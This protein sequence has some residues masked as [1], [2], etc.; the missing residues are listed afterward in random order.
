MDRISRKFAGSIPDG[1]S[2]IFHLHNPSCRPIAVGSTQPLTEMSTR[3]IVWRREGKVGRCLGLTTLPPSCADGLKSGS[4]NLLEP[5]GP[6]QACNG[7][8]LPLYGQNNIIS[9]AKIWTLLQVS[10]AYRHP[11]G[12][13]VQRAGCIAETCRMVQD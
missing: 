7:I 12:A 5:S 9:Y 8:A 4:L 10:Q 13:S 3:S 2:G 11:Q 1:V 6:V